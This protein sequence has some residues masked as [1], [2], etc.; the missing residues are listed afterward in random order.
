MNAHPDTAA[1]AA[2]GLYIERIAAA[3]KANLI[4]QARRLGA[5]SPR[6]SSWVTRIIGVLAGGRHLGNLPTA[7]LALSPT[8][9]RLLAVGRRVAES[10]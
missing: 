3:R 4:N 5:T 6:R 2:R 10:P 9:R 1:A 7:G 8:D